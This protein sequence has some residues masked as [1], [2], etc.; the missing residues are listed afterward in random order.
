MKI[1]FAILAVSAVFMTIAFRSASIGAE[2]SPKNIPFVSC[3]SD[4]QQGPQPPLNKPEEEFTSENAVPPELTLY[5]AKWTPAVLAPSGWFC[6]GTY[7]SSGS[8]LVVTPEPHDPGFMFGKVAITGPAVQVNVVYGS[9]SGR[10]EAAQIAARLFPKASD[11]VK[12]VIGE[13]LVPENDFPV[14]PY[15][16]DQLSY[17]GDFTVE[18]VTPPNQEG[19]GTRYFLQKND[20]QIHGVVAMN[21]DDDHDTMVVTVR[22]PPSLEKLA[23]T[24]IRNGH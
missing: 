19:M 21:P 2:T 7:G 12:S 9:T 4:G 18:Y 22:L 23:P 10:F 16:N 17:K 14:G 6:A 20:Q 13:H 24:I 11:F 5:Q 3:A 8:T 1:I 15:P